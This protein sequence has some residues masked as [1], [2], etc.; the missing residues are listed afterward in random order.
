MRHRQHDRRDRKLGTMTVEGGRYAH[1][2]SLC[3][4]SICRNAA[5]LEFLK[6]FAHSIA[7]GTAPPSAADEG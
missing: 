6:G 3:T 4:G 1:R 7:A 5:W 2:P